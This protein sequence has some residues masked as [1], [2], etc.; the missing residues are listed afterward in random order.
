LNVRSS[1]NAKGSVITDEGSTIDVSGTSGDLDLGRTPGK[2]HLSAAAGSVEVASADGIVLAGALKANRPDASV[3]GGQFKL[4]LSREGYTDLLVSGPGIQAYSTNERQVNVLG[5][6]ADVT[7]HGAQANQAVISSDNLLSAGFD[8]IEL[9]ADDKI[10]LGSGV[11]LAANPGVAG[12]VPLRSLILT[13]PVLSADDHQL[14]TLQAAYVSLGNR[15]LVPTKG[16]TAF[17][18]PD[19]VKG[20][21]GLTV[22]AGLIELYGDSALQ[23]FGSGATADATVKLNATLSAQNEVGQRRDGEVRL[24]G[25]SFRNGNQLN[26]QLNFVGDLSITAGQIYATTLSHYTLQGALGDS[27]LTTLQ[28]SNGSTSATPLSAFGD[29]TLAAYDI[30]HQGVIRQ[31]FGS[32][33]LKAENNAFL[34]DDSILSVTGDGV[35]VPVGTTIN[36]AQW[37]YD[38][39]G[40]VFNEINPQSADATV[41]SS[42]LSLSTL[43]VGKGVLVKGK[44][45]TIASQAGLQAQAGGDVL[46]WEFSAGVGGSTDT[47]NRPGVFAILPGYT[48]DFAPN[49]AEITAS[50]KAAGTTLNAGDQVEVMTGSSVLAAGRYTLLPARYAVLPGA[51][52]VSKSSLKTPTTLT[53]ALAP[54]DD[55]SVQVSG[56][57]TGVGTQINGGNDKTLA[58]TLEPEATFRAKSTLTVTSIND[59][60]TRA[61]EK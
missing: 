21:A 49:D 40:T 34:A 45:L 4:S 27:T 20:D 12:S 10:T 41:N 52:L 6:A 47:L 50:T 16:L 17:P 11:N 3:S 8:R 33:S 37:F 56:Y 32:I 2:T 18:V 9:R 19:A 48:Y 57:K 26:G 42:S 30:H 54:S 25:T 14:H 7:S 43:P 5:A 35:N 28:P 51:V 60:L 15:D 39:Q 36:G 29:L 53:T 46:A 61:A 44:G 59:Y 23:G 13:S 31:P 58:L 55:G 24:V 38:T 22:N 1:G